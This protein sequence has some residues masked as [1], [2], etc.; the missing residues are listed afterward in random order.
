MQ[1]EL[2]TLHTHV[3]LALDGLLAFTPTL[4]AIQHSVAAEVGDAALALMAWAWQRRAILAPQRDDLLG[5][6][7][8]GWRTAAQAVMAA[9]D[10]A[11]RTSSAIENWHSLLR[12]HLAVHRTLSPG[13]LA[14]L[15]VWHNHRVFTRGLHTGLNPLHLSGMTDAPSDWLVALGYPPAK[16]PTL[17]PTPRLPV[18]RLARAA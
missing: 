4:E 13:S 10:A 2:D 3:R 11:V 5:G 8:E 14:L 7:A 15:A 12:P 1:G 18:T 17:S 6:L 9:W 16:T